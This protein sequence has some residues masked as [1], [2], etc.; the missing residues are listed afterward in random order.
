[1]KVVLKYG[2]GDKGMKDFSKFYLELNSKSG[3][4][5]PSDYI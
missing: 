4:R 2:I 1:M 3:D 5:T